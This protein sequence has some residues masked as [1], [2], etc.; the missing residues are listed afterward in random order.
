MEAVAKMILNEKMAELE[1]RLSG[2]HDRI[3]LYQK[4]PPQNLEKEIQA[5]AKERSLNRQELEK[6]LY[7]SKAEMVRALGSM[8][9]EIQGV[10]RKG[11]KNLE[12]KAPGDG[13]DK[14]AEGKI[15]LAE[16]ALDFAC[17]AA[18]CS[19]QLSLEAMNAQ[20][21]QEQGKKK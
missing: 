21:L 20:L 14:D 6:K 9:Q 19:L 16:Y 12:E 4:I 7:S 13:G 5:L 18:D 1:E 3:R 2:L 15:L 11:I 17:Q 8:Y 10:I